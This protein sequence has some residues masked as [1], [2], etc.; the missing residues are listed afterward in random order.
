M[1]RVHQSIRLRCSECAVPAQRSSRGIPRGL[2]VSHY[3]AYSSNS[4]VSSRLQRGV[5]ASRLVAVP[6][7]ASALWLL[8]RTRSDSA[9]AGC[10]VAQR[11]LQGLIEQVPLISAALLPLHAHRVGSDCS[12]ATEF[13][14][15][16]DGTLPATTASAGATRSRNNRIVRR[17]FH[18][19]PLCYP[20]A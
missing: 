1:R 8:A 15:S 5:T 3:Q 2:P 6:H 13:G 10:V 16:P 4:A 17:V 19:S 9:F 12:L 11:C 14:P 7:A 20:R 18:I